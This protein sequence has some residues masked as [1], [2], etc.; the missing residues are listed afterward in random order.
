LVPTPPS[1]FPSTSNALFFFC[2]NL[3]PPAWSQLITI[4]VTAFVAALLS[5]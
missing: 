4:L 3:L 5:D 1:H 2:V